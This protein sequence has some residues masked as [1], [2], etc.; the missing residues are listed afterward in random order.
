MGDNR[1]SYVWVIALAYGGARQRYSTVLPQDSCRNEVPVLTPKSNAQEYELGT[2]CLWAARL[3]GL[4]QH[5]TMY[6]TQACLL[7]NLQRKQFWIWRF[8]LHANYKLGDVNYKPVL[9]CPSSITNQPIHCQVF[10]MKSFMCGVFVEHSNGWPLTSH[11][12]IAWCRQHW[13]SF[14]FLCFRRE[15][16]QR[17]PP[18]VWIL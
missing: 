11:V 4:N 16:R 18:S 2:A 17:C 7:T 6:L 10:G 15:G 12:C 14:G 9:S 3:C 1:G 8:Y 13:V 5:T